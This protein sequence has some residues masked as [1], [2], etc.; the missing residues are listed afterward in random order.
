MK[1]IQ[2]KLQVITSSHLQWLSGRFLWLG[3]RRPDSRHRGRHTRRLQQPSS[4]PSGH[5]PTHTEIHYGFAAWPLSRHH[6]MISTKYSHHLPHIRSGSS[7]A[8]SHQHF[9]VNISILFEAIS[10]WIMWPLAEQLS[11]LEVKVCVDVY[12]LAHPDQGFQV[13]LRQDWI[14]GGS[15]YFRILPSI[16]SC[17]SAEYCLSS[18][19]I[20]A[21]TFGSMNDLQFRNALVF[22]MYPHSA[23][24]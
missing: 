9:Q 17:H 20:M 21:N 6:S 1:Q 3:G 16:S 11:C 5:Q 19:V 18:W 24:T 12:R 2:H 23:T 10:V 7:H 13:H 14:F 4:F 8:V 15:D 22:P